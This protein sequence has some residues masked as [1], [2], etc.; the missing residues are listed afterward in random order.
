MGLFTEWLYGKGEN[1][2]H[3][4]ELFFAKTPD[5]LK[6]AFSDAYFG[7]NCTVTP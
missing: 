2:R 6:E 3:L 4:A 7:K 1:S 5:F